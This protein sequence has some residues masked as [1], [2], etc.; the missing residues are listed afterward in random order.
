LAG[1]SDTPT[2]SASAE[3]YNPA[4]DAW[5]NTFGPMTSMRAQ[6]QAVL[7][8]DGKVLVAGGN[9]DFNGVTDGLTAELFDP[10][11]GLETP[12]SIVLVPSSTFVGGTFQFNFTATPG[13]SFTVWST[14][15]IST[16]FSSWTSLGPVTETSSGHFHF[17]DSQAASLERKFYRVVSP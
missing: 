16:P 9:T 13:Q 3:I 7:L 5:I 6:Q 11:A 4:T 12:I 10:N 15:D 1:A 8:P 17:S 2:K 14:A